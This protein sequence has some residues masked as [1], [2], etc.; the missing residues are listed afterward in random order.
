MAIGFIA[1]LILAVLPPP[2]PVM[3]LLLVGGWFVLREIVD[4]LAELFGADAGRAQRRHDERMTQMQHRHERWRADREARLGDP[5]PTVGRAIQGRIARWIEGSG[6]RIKRSSEQAAAEQKAGQRPGGWRAALRRA[7]EATVATCQG[8]A[9][10]AEER[11]DARPRIVKTLTEPEAE[12]AAPD[13]EVAVVADDDQEPVAHPGTPPAAP[14]GDGAALPPVPGFWQDPETIMVPDPDTVET[15]RT[16]QMISVAELRRRH[17]QRATD[18]ERAHELRLAELENERLAAVPPQASLGR[19][20]HLALVP[21]PIEGEIPMTDTLNLA[22][23]H[24]INPESGIALT[25]SV[26]EV[27]AALHERL[28]TSIAAVERANV[29]PA[30]VADITELA[31][32]ATAMEDKAKQMVETFQAHLQVRGAVQSAGAGT[33]ADYLGQQ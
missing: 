3:I 29:D 8:W 15:G 2:L 30:Q 1:F 23:G 18:A 10:Q 11:L 13:D 19:V 14:G 9:Q 17:D 25:T 28:R 32:L 20:P 26:A 7:K 31:N 21:N 24:T 6:T 22:S 12:P 27:A 33:N 5:H 4:G 16:P